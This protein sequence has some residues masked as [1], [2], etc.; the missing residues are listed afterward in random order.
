MA[1]YDNILEAGPELI[2]RG[3]ADRQNLLRK[4]TE[5]FLRELS[6]DY[7]SR[8][9]LHWKR[10]YSSVEDYEASVAPN[11]EAW[12]QAIGAFEAPLLPLEARHEPFLFRFNLVGHGQ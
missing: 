8:R 3:V 1:F 7:E 9:E 6:L 12:R 10:D 4:E 2:K 5:D 11:R